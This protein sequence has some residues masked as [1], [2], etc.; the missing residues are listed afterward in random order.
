M[1]RVSSHTVNYRRPFQLYHFDSKQQHPQRR[2]ITLGGLMQ[3]PVRFLI[4]LST[5]LNL[6]GAGAA[7]AEVYV[8]RLWSDQHQDYRV[9]PLY[10][11][12]TS[13]TFSR[14]YQNAYGQE[15]DLTPGPPFYVED[16]IHAVNLE[17][18]DSSQVDFGVITFQTALVRH[19]EPFVVY[20]F[21]DIGAG[22][23]GTIIGE[24]GVNFK[25]ST[26]DPITIQGTFKVI[27]GDAH[28]IC[29]DSIGEHSTTWQNTEFQCIYDEQLTNASPFVI[30]GGHTTIENCYFA[31]YDSA[32][33]QLL[34]FADIYH[35]NSG[36]SPVW[37]MT[38]R[39]TRFE[40]F[41]FPSNNHAIHFQYLKS[42]TIEDCHFEDIT[43]SQTAHPRGPIGLRECGLKSI[44]GNSAVNTDL[45]A[46]T[47]MQAWACDSAFVRSNS[48]VPV[49]TSTIHVPEDSALAFGRSTIVKFLDNSSIIN[50]GRL[51][52]DS[53]I[54]TSIHDDRYGG[55][56]DLEPPTDT[57]HSRWGSEL[58]QAILVDSSATAYLDNCRILNAAG[59]IRVLGDIT[60][61]GCYFANGAGSCIRLE[62]GQQ[63]TFHIANTVFTQTVGDAAMMDAAVS[64]DNRSSLQQTLVLDSVR[65]L[66][67]ATNGIY[68]SAI[69]SGDTYLDV[70][71]SQVVGNRGHG[72]TISLG[73]ALAG[74]VVS[75]SLVAANDLSGIY[76]PP[77]SSDGASIR[78]E[79]NAILANGNGVFPSDGHGIYVGSG[80]TPRLIGNTVAYN[81]G[82]GIETEGVLNIEQ[83]EYVNNL[84]YANRDHGFIERSAGTPLVAANAFWG[85]EGNEVY[86]R[87]P[88]D[89]WVFTVEDLQAFGGDFTTNLHSAPDLIPEILGTIDTVMFDIALG[90]SLIIDTARPWAGTDIT[91]FLICPDTLAAEWSRVVSTRGDSLYVLG[92]VAAVSSPGASY[93]LFDYHLSG[94]SPLLDTG[95]SSNTTEVFDIDGNVR[96]LD[97]DEDGSLV[98]DIGADEYMP[99]GT[100]Q[101]TVTLTYPRGGEFFLAGDTCTITWQSSELDSLNVLFTDYYLGPATVWDTVAAGIDASGGSCAWEMPPTLSPRCMIRLEDAADSSCN[102]ASSPF[103]VKRLCLTRLEDD[104]TLTVYMSMF[105]SWPF[106]NDSAAMWP[107][108]W[109]SQFDYA[110]GTDPYTGRVYPAFFSGPW[111]YDA[112][113]SDFPDWETFVRAFGINQCYFNAPA[114]LMYRP[115]A[116]AYWAQ[117]KGDWQGSCFGFNAG[118]ALAFFD[119]TAFYATYP[120]VGPPAQTHDLALT[121]DRRQVLNEL[122]VHQY[123]RHHAQHMTDG[124][125]RTPRETLAEL[126]GVMADNYV[127]GPSLIIGSLDT[128]GGA[129]SL[130][131]TR[132]ES[133]STTP[134]KWRIY[135]YDS[136]HPVP[137]TA[138]PARF[139]EIDS[140]ANTWSYSEYPGWSGPKGICYLMDSS[141]SYLQAPVMP[142]KL[143]ES[144]DRA[145]GT[146]ETT[147]RVDQSRATTLRISDSLGHTSG[148]DSHHVYQDIPG[149][150][151]LVTVGSRL[152]KPRGYVLPDG[153]YAIDVG[154]DTN[155]TV[156][157]SIW[158]DSL[159]FGYRRHS[160]RPGQIDNL[161]YDS[162]LTVINNDD[163]AKIGQFD[164]IVRR[165]DGERQF[166]LDSFIID[167]GA[168]WK[169]GISNDNSLVI[170]TDGSGQTCDLIIRSVTTGQG[171]HVRA[172][173][174]LLHGSAVNTVVPDWSSPG[175]KDVM[176]YYDFDADG[177]HDDST[178]VSVSTAI[179]GNDS[180]GGLPTEYRLHRNYPNPFNP[181][182]LISYDLPHQ[183]DVRLTVYNVLGQVVR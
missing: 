123:G 56:S 50:E 36:E 139:V 18:V 86:F 180:H 35:W 182:T 118:S 80:T 63:S 1:L 64:F 149:A 103:T 7:Y 151:A 88:G 67:N 98:V 33:F 145:G 42:V 21:P 133:D 62:S 162:C 17:A 161:L 114:G 51:W 174:I 32:F 132:L 112:Q 30:D 117:I 41:Y 100:S 142:Y 137:D 111:F 20:V 104:T 106:A 9:Q 148:F 16:R 168:S 113:P 43:L 138:A 47:F 165:L 105:D 183:A 166:V 40:R 81:Q 83:A 78:F 38:V 24:G 3:R 79:G 158:Q 90:R 11:E 19:D 150:T 121:D 48:S 34:L 61:N 23:G 44:K 141:A 70:R 176:L 69:G 109:F 167:S 152:S 146:F 128:A 95:Y 125:H 68:L 153:V 57:I 26:F 136:N 155:T 101:A 10:L 135:V 66:D 156:G 76:A 175:L 87:G 89:I 96:I 172:E 94:T 181:S 107:A 72:I 169:I 93:R 140:A 171:A 102:D 160:N 124:Q 120:E 65:V 2:R 116:V 178:T 110:V 179:G 52:A 15:L 173:N 71:A 22:H 31:N 163:S 157:V 177:V 73:E 37:E 77:H 91:G 99:N 12:G 58:S 170:R 131:P 25:G 5:S 46:L 8:N 143:T 127:N 82:P 115:S 14:D 45:E 54:L 27:S 97:G 59:G 129:H 154:C 85:N 74:A 126:K 119:S 147:I 164:C 55:D 6:L 13:V 144:G 92:D 130:T 49:I 84:V 39:N 29:P 75:N 4:L 53:A 134:G 28:V 108:D 60:V 159:T 122:F